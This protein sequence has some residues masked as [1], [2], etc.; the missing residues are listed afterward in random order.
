MKSLAS[1]E[2]RAT[3]CNPHSN[4]KALESP[5]MKNAVNFIH[6]SHSRFPLSR[7]TCTLFF[8]SAFLSATCFSSGQF[9]FSSHVCTGREASL[10]TLIYPP[11][12][13]ARV[14]IKCEE[15]LAFYEVR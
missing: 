7:L 12:S 11:M 3:G 8:Q 9:Q 10:S 13:F 1:T 2:V 15:T 14:E 6:D 5:P 4:K